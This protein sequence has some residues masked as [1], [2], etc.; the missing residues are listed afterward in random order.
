MTTLES[1]QAM[2]DEEIIELVATQVMEWELEDTGHPA[3]G[4]C[5][6][7]GISGESRTETWKRWWR[8]MHQRKQ[9]GDMVMGDVWSEF[10]KRGWNPLSGSWDD[11]MQVVEKIV[12]NDCE[13]FR[14]SDYKVSCGWEVNIGENGWCIDFNAQ[15]AICIAAILATQ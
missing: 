1:L 2:S 14:L 5:A 4:Y 7:H 3:H 10:T 8:R 15:K 9:K 12:L 11:T 13:R 6:E